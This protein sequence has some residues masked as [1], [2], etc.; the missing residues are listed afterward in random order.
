MSNIVSVLPASTHSLVGG[1]QSYLHYAYSLPIL[2]AEEETELFEQCQQGKNRQAAQKI[3]LSHLRFVAFIAKGYGGYGLP[4]EDL[5]QEGNVGLMKSFKRFDLSYGV[6]FASFAV[7]WIKSEI[8][9][10]VLKN[11]KLVKV[12]TTKA[13]R[14]LFFNLRRM[15]KQLTWMNKDDIQEIANYLSVSTEDVIDMEA[16]LQQ[17]D[18]FFDAS[19]GEAVPDDGTHNIA[20][21]KLL[22]DYS[23]APEY[24]V[25]ESDY[26]KKYLSKIYDSINSLDARSKDIF[27]SRWLKEPEY[28]VSLKTLAEKYSISIER[29]RQIEEQALREI[30]R[31]IEG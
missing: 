12:A 27:T 30:R 17:N 21:T 1:F 29:V 22:E 4:L 2:S 11:W 9:D 15:K 28:K 16:R 26:R 25:S 3:I 8:H 10:Y 5:V 24:L 23:N 14:K 6:R 7:H 20:P 18:C 31:D 13:Q 19:F